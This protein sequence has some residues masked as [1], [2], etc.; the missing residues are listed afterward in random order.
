MDLVEGPFQ[1][2]TGYWDIQELGNNEKCKG[3]ML[4]LSL[5]YSFKNKIIERII[6][7]MFHH[8]TSTLVDCFL[9]EAKKRYADSN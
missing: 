4:T 3:C 6:G 1:T 7:S 9:T 8:I 5:K 2:L